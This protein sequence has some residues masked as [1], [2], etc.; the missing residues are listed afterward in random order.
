MENYLATEFHQLPGNPS[1]NIFKN[2]AYITLTV[3]ANTTCHK[4]MHHLSTQ[5]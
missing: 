2:L 3:A 4:M 1:R 5:N